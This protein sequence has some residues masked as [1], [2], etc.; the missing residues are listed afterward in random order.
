MKAY[1]KENKIF[2]LFILLAVIAALVVTGQRMAVEKADRTVDFVLDYKEAELLAEQSPQ[3]TS[4]WLKEFAGMGIT[5][6]GLAEESLKTLTESDKPVK[7]ELVKELRK[8]TYWLSQAP[9]EVLQLI[10]ENVKDD[11]DV[12]VIAESEEMFS[13]IK[14]AFEERYDP[15]KVHC[16]QSDSGGYI[17]INGAVED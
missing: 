5:K 6:V 1:I 8:D 17:L 12:M 13:F 9:E 10:D 3:D 16:L 7:A 2:F 15:K 14:R 11:F 4:W